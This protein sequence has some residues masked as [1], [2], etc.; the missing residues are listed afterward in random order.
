MASR[1]VKN[2]EVLATEETTFLYG[3][4]GVLTKD[5]MV[6]VGRQ[7]CFEVDFKKGLYW[8]AK[9]GYGDCCIGN[10]RLTVQEALKQEA[11]VL[12]EE[13]R[14]L[15]RTIKH[16]ETKLAAVET[17]LSDSTKIHLSSRSPHA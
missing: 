9:G 7:E 16:F 5:G 15:K 6:V 3:V 11:K 4:L 8:P 12:N 1:T 2:K 13:L 10:L 14:D 17:G